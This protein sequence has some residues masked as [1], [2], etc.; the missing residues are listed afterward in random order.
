MFK[1]AR[2]CAGSVALVDRCLRSFVGEGRS[3]WREERVAADVSGPGT[4]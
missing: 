4:D 3:L 1:D 2:E